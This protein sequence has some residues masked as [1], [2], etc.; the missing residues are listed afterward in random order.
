MGLRRRVVAEGLREVRL[1][2]EDG[3]G[4]GLGLRLGSALA[5]FL[6][7]GVLFFLTL[8]CD[9]RPAAARRAQEKR[10]VNAVHAR[11]LALLAV[12]LAV[13]VSPLL[14]GRLL[15]GRLG[16]RDLCNSFVGDDAARD[17]VARVDGVQDDAVKF[18]LRTVFDVCA[19]HFCHVFVSPRVI[20]AIFRNSWQGFQR[21]LLKL[22]SSGG[23]RNRRRAN[24]MRLS[25][26]KTDLCPW[27]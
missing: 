6:G 12:A 8:L 19:G 26:A 22:H 11:P 2:G 27:R 24:G 21:C 15:L 25:R 20:W 14:L 16:G 1:L 5:V 9:P 13:E 18:D 23:S 10:Q 3:L 17:D 4:L 7:L